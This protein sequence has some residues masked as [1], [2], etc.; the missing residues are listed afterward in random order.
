MGSHLRI[1]LTGGIG[2]G[3][4]TV[5]RY[6]A[7]L[8][9]TIIDT[10]RI[11]HA[12]VEPGQPALAEI[13]AGF[14]DSVLDADGRLD[15]AQLRKIVFQ[16][17]DRRRQLENILHPLIRASALDSAEKSSGPYCVLVIPLLVETGQDYL[18]DR[19]LVI[20]SPV[21]LQIRRVTARDRL[22]EAEIRAILASQASRQERLAVADDV[23]SNDA[24]LESL[25]AQ[26]QRLHLFYTQLGVKQS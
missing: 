25:Q 17:A 11:A 18:L 2:S 8:G 15:R 5:S 22:S 1:G 6:F 12:L 10:D 14:G 19:I 23:I 16:D 4:S 20:D 21:E 3:K 9:A 26:T 7:D 24:D 13:V